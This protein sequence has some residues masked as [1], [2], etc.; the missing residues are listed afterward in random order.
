MLAN[1][2]KYAISEGVAKLAPF[3]TTLYVAKNLS[4]DEFGRY[5]LIFI[6]YELS[7]ILITFNIQATTRIDFFKLRRGFFLTSKREHLLISLL[8]AFFSVVISF[9]LDYE[10]QYIFIILVLSSFIRCISVFQLAIFQC[11]KRSSSYVTSNLVFTISL[12]ILTIIFVSLGFSYFSWLYS[13]LLA[14]LIQ[15]LISSALFGY[16]RTLLFLSLNRIDFNYQSLKSTFIVALFFL[17]QA[18]GW[19]LKLGADRWII[20]RKLGTAFLG[21]YSLAFQFSSVLLIAA[22]VINLVLVP[23]LNSCLKNNNLKRIKFIMSPAVVFLVFL[24]MAIYFVASEVIV[25]FYNSDYLDSIIYLKLLVLPFLVQSFIL[26]FSNILYYLGNGPY[27]A[28]LILFT[29]SLQIVINY[30]Y[31]DKFGIS[32]MIAISFFAN[33][34]VLIMI[35]LKS[36]IELKARLRMSSST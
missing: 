36:L 31:V 19:W 22:T 35:I 18:L 5:S 24:S 8:L 33:F 7:F 1:L 6:V 21:K 10:S 15:L 30:Y 16:T 14:S 26:L 34:F 32:G 27:M 11:E 25:L 28:K 9:V 29:F 3:I 12:S 20:E 2:L 17:P 23:A 13:L 4:A